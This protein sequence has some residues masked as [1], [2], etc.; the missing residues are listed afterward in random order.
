MGNLQ[1]LETKKV[2]LANVYEIIKA[3]RQRSLNI[4]EEQLRR[5][6]QLEA[7]HKSVEEEIK[8]LKEEI[9]NGKKEW[10]R[11]DSKRTDDSPLGGDPG[12]RKENRKS[13]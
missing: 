2:V 5:M 8:K 7:D 13:K 9:E 6:I 4:A 11:N 12:T 3:E 1:E 10:K